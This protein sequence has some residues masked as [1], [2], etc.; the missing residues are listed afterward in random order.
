MTFHAVLLHNES[1]WL[2]TYC[3]WSELMGVFPSEGTVLQQHTD[4]RWLLIATLPLRKVHLSSTV[5]LHVHSANG[6]VDYISNRL[7]SSPA[8]WHSKK[9]LDKD[10]Y[11]YCI[12]MS[13]VRALPDDCITQSILPFMKTLPKIHQG[14]VSCAVVVMRRRVLPYD[15]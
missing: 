14:R 12:N 1:L 5:S 8:P 9:H 4:T 15:F 10:L 2:Y 7:S 11:G 6:A 13:T 3:M